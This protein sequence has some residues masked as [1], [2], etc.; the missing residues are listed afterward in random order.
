MFKK[1]PSYLLFLVVVAS[2]SAQAAVIPAPPALSATGYILID[3]DS[4]QILVDKNSHEQLPPASLTKMMTSYVLSA[5][6]A[7]GR[8]D[9]SDMVTISEAAWAQN[10]VFN[11][12][13]L[14]W[15]EVG[16]QVKLAD[17]HR[18]VI[19]SSGNDASVA[20]AEYLAGN[21]DEFANLMNKHAELLGMKDTQFKNS[22][23]LPANDQYSSAYD[24]SLLAKAIIQ[25]YP[26]DYAIYKEREFTYNQIR[27][28]NR[29]RLLWRDPSVDG[30]KTGHTQEAGYGLVASAK[31]SDMRLISV[32]MGTK[33]S[34]ARERDTQRLL[35]Y[36]FRFY[37]T[38][39]LYAPGTE[40]SSAKVWGGVED[41]VKLGVS[42]SISLTIPRGRH[43]D[44]EAMMSIDS[45]VK[46][47]VLK[48]AEYGELSIT[49]DG[50][51]LYT[52]PLV[53]QTGVEEG[54]LF[55]R[56]WHGI[57]LFFQGFFG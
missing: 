3:A 42:K 30:L 19:I 29:N 10:P 20:V 53:A 25:N 12:S 49:L 36:G 22:H 34:A 43:Q 51:E 47:P 27:Q 41:I 11:G 38:H 50:E 21:E 8:V 48:G 15:I 31:K 4:G 57:W 26:K 32:V 7:A 13:S 33:S 5:E 39:T 54:G 45:A 1:I 52:A 24:L 9:K 56:L 18:G 2:L 37:E 16:K 14:M 35:A 40:L 28:P 44:I 6:L 17:L 55:K 23:G 46:A